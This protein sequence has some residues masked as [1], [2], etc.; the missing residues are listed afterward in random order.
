MCHVFEQELIFALG[1]APQISND[2]KA[3]MLHFMRVITG[4]YAR[5]TGFTFKREVCAG[6]HHSS[7]MQVSQKDTEQESEQELLDVGVQPTQPIL[8]K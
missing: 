7:G 5:F 3:L 6:L 8:C 2:L 1:I 4:L